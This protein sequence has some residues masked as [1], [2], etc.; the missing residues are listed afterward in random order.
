YAEQKTGSSN[1]RYLH[2]F[3]GENMD[4]KV[5]T[6][7]AHNSIHEEEFFNIAQSLVF[8]NRESNKM[9]I[10]N[11]FRE[12]RDPRVMAVAE[13]ILDKET[14]GIKLFEIDIEGKKGSQERIKINKND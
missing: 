8:Y 4:K 14:A 12:V 2:I 5:V 9:T 10:D 13:E 1:F 3:M 7:S 6:L 11:Y